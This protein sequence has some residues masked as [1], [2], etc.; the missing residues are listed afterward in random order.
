MTCCPNQ[1]A[2]MI[3]PAIYSKHRAPVELLAAAARSLFVAYP[4]ASAM[5]VRETDK[6]AAIALKIQHRIR[7]VLQK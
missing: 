2:M 4:P 6:T 5:L 7:D 1:I 3:E